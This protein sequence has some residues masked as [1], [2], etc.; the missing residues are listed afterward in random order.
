MEDFF[1]NYTEQNISQYDHMTYDPYGDSYYMLN[2]YFYDNYT[3]FFW[4]PS[5]FTINS[6]LISRVATYIFVA[7][8][9]PL[10]LLAIYSVYFMVRS[11]PVAA[12]YVINLLISD[13]IQLCCMFIV[14]LPSV[15][16]DLSSELYEVA[17]LA[18][19]GFMVSLSIERYMVIVHPLWY[20]IRRSVKFSLEERVR[21][22]AFECC[23]VLQDE[24]Q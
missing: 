6:S 3:T 12:I 8:G 9:M 11:D 18:S 5:G 22:K 14:E 20:R 2:W 17:V 16:W 10:I 13:L 1:G 15:Y 21:I 24:E 7:I 23:E 4:H 19:V